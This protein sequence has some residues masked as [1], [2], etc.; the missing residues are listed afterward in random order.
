MGRASRLV[1]LSADACF[2]AGGV[3]GEPVT[4][5]AWAAV[6]QGS[7]LAPPRK[8]GGVLAGAAGTVKKAKEGI[9]L[10]SRSHPGGGGRGSPLRP[11]RPLRSRSRRA[12]V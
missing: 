7:L 12:S 2:R 9:C 1:D 8:F 11:R 6:M 5:P 10:L 4:P 3:P